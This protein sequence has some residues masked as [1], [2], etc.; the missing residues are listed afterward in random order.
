MDLKPGMQKSVVTGSFD[1]LRSSG[2]RFLEEAARRGE[3]HVY[4]W[5]DELVRRLEGHAPKFSL[6]E[7]TYLLQ[8]IRY[9][10]QV[11]LVDQL[12]DRDGLPPYAECAGAAWVVEEGDDTPQKHAFCASYGMH[13]Q[14]V[15]K[16][17]LVSFPQDQTPAVPEDTAGRP[18][19]VVTG[20]YDWFHSGHV[21]FFEEVSGLG[22]LYVVVGSDENVR[23]LKGPGHPMFPQ[24]ERRYVVQSIRFVKQAL[25]SSGS[26][27]MDAE[28]EI[29]WI[30]PHIYAVNE[31]GDQPEKRDFCAAHGIRY[32]V[33]Q[34]LPKDGLPRRQSVDL[35]GF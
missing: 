25:I 17:V 30:K 7:R 13:Y 14:V 2:V 4:L 9:V 20:C 15:K 16:D 19:V 31:D 21:R 12:S 33:L 11:Q 27:W 24:E 3:L 8:A 26:G 23:L 35:R 10:H 29:A 6:G 34:R 18:R 28:P 32:V 22:D 5:S 1:D